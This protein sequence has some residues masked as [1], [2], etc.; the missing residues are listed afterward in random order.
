M[1]YKTIWFPADGTEPTEVVFNSLPEVATAIT[2]NAQEWEAS[3]R[4]FYIDW[5]DDSE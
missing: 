5:V 4:G 3:A 1:K 2:Q